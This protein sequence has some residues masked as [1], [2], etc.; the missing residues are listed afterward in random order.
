MDRLVVEDVYKSGSSFC[1]KVRFPEKG[2]EAQESIDFNE[3][4]ND[5]W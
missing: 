5:I 2:G 1:R 3:K 4:Q